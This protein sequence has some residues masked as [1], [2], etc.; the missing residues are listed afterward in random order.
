MGSESISF[1]AFILSQ[2]NRCGLAISLKHAELCLLVCWNTPYNADV[3]SVQVV[4]V[5]VVAPTDFSGVC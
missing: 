4:G 2:T 3:Q 5:L 1:V